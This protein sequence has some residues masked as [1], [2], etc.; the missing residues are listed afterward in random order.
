MCLLFYKITH[1]AITISLN[2]F[3][4]Q[5]KVFLLKIKNNT[6]LL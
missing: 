3:H 2:N 5:I 6:M 4:K 1:N